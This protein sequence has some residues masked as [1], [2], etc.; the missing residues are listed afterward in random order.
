M[1][2]NVDGVVAMRKAIQDRR[3]A[4]RYAEVNKTIDQ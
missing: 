4:R 2:I 1:N 3:N